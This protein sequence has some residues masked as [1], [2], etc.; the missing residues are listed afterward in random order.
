MLSIVGKAF[1]GVLLNS[2]QVLA[3]RVYPK[4]QYGFRAARSTVDMVFSVRQLQE[5]C[6][7]QRR[8][9]YLAFEDLTKAF[10]LVSRGGLFAL[11]KTIGCPPKLLSMIVSFHENLKVTFQFDSSCSE[12]F[13]IKKRCETELRPCTHTVWD[14]LLPV[15]SICI[16]RLRRR[17]LHTHLKQWWP[18]HPA[19]LRAKTKISKV[20]IRKRLF[21]DDAALVAYSGEAMLRLIDGLTTACYEF[22]FT[23]SLK[24][25]EVVLQDVSDATP[26]TLWKSSLISAQQPPKIFLLNQS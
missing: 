3:D 16:R 26:S 13:I 8:P 19:R 25:T 9:I 22:G 23:I 11:L 5:K 10:D 1:A 4:A 20:L 17:C 12:L 14:F 21:A 2:L 6:R 7:E 24:K 15:V 18:F